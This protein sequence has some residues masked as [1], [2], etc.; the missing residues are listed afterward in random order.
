MSSEST[1]E[2]DYRAT[3]CLPV[4]DFPMRAELARREPERV[5]WW[6]ERDVYARRLARN[7]GNPPWI[8]HDGPPYA[9]GEVHMGT[10]LN[11]VLK[12]IFVKV[13]LLEGRAA[14]FVPGWDMHGLPIEFETVKHL[15]ID[16]HEIDPIELRAKCR[17][18]AEHWLDVQR[19]TFLRMGVFGEFDHPYRTIDPEFE[20]TIVETLADLAE[21]GYLYKGLRATLW[22]MHDE[23]ALA[24]AEVEYR[25][26]TSP[27]IFVRFPANYGQRDELL[28]R[29]ERA[30]TLAPSAR[31]GVRPLSILIWTTTP[32][33]LPANEAIALRPDARYG[34]YRHGNEDLVVAEALAASV[35]ARSPG[36][37]PL[38][39][40]SA[41]GSDLIGAK[42]RHPFA[43]RDALVV[44]AEYVELET[45]TGAVHT[46]PGHGADD[47]ETGMRYGLVVRSP[48][49]AAGRF[50]AEAGPYAGL[51]VF[52]ANPK[53][54]ADLTA[55]GMLFAS[56]E[57]VHS[58][59]HCWRCKNPLIFRATAQWF[60]ALDHRRLR[61]RIEEQIPRVAW[62][63]AW[64][65][66]RMQAT[67]ANH[68]EWCIS[69]QRT[70]GTPIPAVVCRDCGT[71]LVDPE[72]ARNLARAFR[73]YGHPAPSST[74]ASDLW[75]TEPLERFLPEHLT[76]PQCGGRSFEK[77]F[78]IVD[79]WF[80]SGVTHR[81]VLEP[82]GMPWPA[83]LYLEGADQFRGWFR[84]NLV[85]A[86]AT[87]GAPPYRGVATT[88]W[89]VDAE[90]RAMH[91]SAGNYVPA[92]EAIERYG[93]DVL[94]LWATSVE[95]TADMRFGEKLL[96]AVAS[97]YR[98][99]RYRLRMLL[100]LVGDLPP[101]ERLAR[102]RLVPL[103]RLA[104][105]RFDA[106]AG[107]VAEHYRAFRL[108]DVYLALVEYDTSELSR[109][110]I[111]L[112]KDPMYSGQRDG[113][114]RRSAQSALLA[115]LEGMLAMLAPILSFTAE[116]AWQHLPEALR[117][118]RASVFELDLPRPRAA[119]PQDRADLGFWERLRELRATVAAHTEPRDFALQA[120]V[121]AGSAL[122]ERLA[123]LGDGLREAL[124]VSACTL[125]ADPALAADDVRIEL[126]PAG[127]EKCARCWKYLP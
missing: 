40:A 27:S 103:D 59:P 35:F 122:G 125:A 118:G 115:I 13:A 10:F 114:R 11:R 19:A 109:F 104:L 36:A 3:L 46:A 99:L 24:E 74:N 43:D 79:I 108:H 95:F 55:R 92:L 81:A 102:E 68:P 1:L 52:E 77:E 83:D 91:K 53:I 124:V 63:P 120:H 119:G 66:A 75:W 51:G 107:A 65:E 45:G 90:G 28:G 21:G 23:T 85:T 123:A 33:T 14:R 39:L 5:A 42:V 2:R 6:R 50:T 117:A 97:V 67:I 86:V 89:V 88:G 84:S 26:R 60:I 31:E 93:A 105:V 18:R 72:L 94:R 121:V 38:Q 100:S 111:D 64:G 76:C 8:L 87:R 57:H 113:L 44:G 82:R 49:D 47:F 101:G 58:Y 80:E 9:N 61:R 41:A 106:L 56:E 15:G 62:Y 127:G 126:A 110:Y 98:N 69:R 37:L 34:L 4:T 16:F 7:V 17:E 30:G 20:A 73:S 22:C 32:W 71:S 78:N 12:D 116:E 29:F 25:E 70:W 48:V 54:V 96:E 112:L